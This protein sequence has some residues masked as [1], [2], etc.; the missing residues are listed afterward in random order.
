M[1]GF[2][3]WGTPFSSIITAVGC[4]QPL[5][6]KSQFCRMDHLGAVFGALIGD[7]SP[8]MGLS[9]AL[10]LNSR[11]QCITPIS[12]LPMMAMRKVWTQKSWVSLNAHSRATA[13][14]FPPPV[15]V[16]CLSA[17]ISP[18]GVALSIHEL[19]GCKNIY[20]VWWLVLAKL[21]QGC[22]NNKICYKP[23]LFT[24]PNKG[25]R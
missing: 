25:K 20:V 5:P 8:Y 2:I 6:Q 11:A 14:R 15:I 22:R 1:W 17:P 7:V 23:N 24:H 10:Q 12:S 3:W 18:L 9:G 13:F 19:F 4:I 21:S 16:S